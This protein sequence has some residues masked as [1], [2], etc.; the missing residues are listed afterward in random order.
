MTLPEGFLALW[1]SMDALFSRVEPTPWGAVVTDGRYPRIWDTNYAR[2]EA[3]GVRLPEVV[4]ALAPALDSIGATIFHVV[5]F[6]PE[7]SAR[8]LTDLSRR[9]H[10]LGW[11]LVMLSPAVRAAPNAHKVHEV[12]PGPELWN[13]VEASLALLGDEP[14]EAVAQIRA[15]ETDVLAPGG[16]RWFGV[17]DDAGELV[18]LAALLVLAGAGYVDNVATLPRARGR[19]MAS[20]VTAHAVGEAATQGVRQVFLVADPD[21]TEVVRMYERLGFRTAVRLASTRGPVPQSTNL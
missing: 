5:M 21:A 14:K 20:A 4:E 16:K 17:R 18:S 15:I 6:N 8:L 13:A 2:V 3:A 12:S 1:R 7:G 11:D 9:G 19:G 10:R